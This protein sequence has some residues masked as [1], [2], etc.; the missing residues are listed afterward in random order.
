MQRVYKSL[1]KAL[2]IA[3]KQGKHVRKVELPHSHKI[4]AGLKDSFG[5]LLKDPKTGKAYV[6]RNIVVM[7]VFYTV[8]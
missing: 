5:Q 3:T 6:K 2:R 7:R 8:V 4:L 1:K